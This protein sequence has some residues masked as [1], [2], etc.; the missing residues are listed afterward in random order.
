[1]GYSRGSAGPLSDA[2]NRPDQA[3]TRLEANGVVGLAAD[4]P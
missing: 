4:S 1:M 2:G 3:I